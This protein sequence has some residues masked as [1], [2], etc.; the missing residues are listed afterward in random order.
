[1]KKYDNAQIKS[2]NTLI[3]HIKQDSNLNDKTQTILF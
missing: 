2:E 3:W 1:M